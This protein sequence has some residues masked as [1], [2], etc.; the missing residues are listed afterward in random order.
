MVARSADAQSPQAIEQ[1][2][3]QIVD[4]L[5]EPL[6]NCHLLSAVRVVQ[7]LKKSADVLFTPLFHENIKRFAH[8]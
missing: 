3:E 7:V 6:A 4:K 1:L 2:Y 8:M 5:Q